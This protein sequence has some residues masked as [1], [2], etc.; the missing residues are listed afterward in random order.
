M[1]TYLVNFSKKSICYELRVVVRSIGDTICSQSSS[2][3]VEIEQGSET[4]GFD[5]ELVVAIWRFISTQ[6]FRVDRTFSS[7]PLS[8]HISSLNANEDLNATLLTFTPLLINKLR[9]ILVDSQYGTMFDN[10]R[11]FFYPPYSYRHIPSPSVS[12]LPPQKS[13]CLP[14]AEKTSE[15]HPPPWTRPIFLAV[16]FPRAGSWINHISFSPTARTPSF[17]TFPLTTPLCQWRF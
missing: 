2:L 16:T 4:R 11:L 7:V 14:W 8:C 10:I 13:D 3:L 9:E 12:S 5:Y 1:A 6:M 17:A 15:I